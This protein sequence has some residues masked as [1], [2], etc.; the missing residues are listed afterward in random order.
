MIRAPL[1]NRMTPVDDVLDELGRDL[2]LT[3]LRFDPRG[4]V[5]LRFASGRCFSFETRDDALVLFVAEPVRHALGERVL[6]A[7]RRADASRVSPW[8]VQVV[9]RDDAGQP[10]LLAVARLE[11]GSVA[12]PEARRLLAFLD[13]WN[14]PR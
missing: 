13:E 7:M 5:S 4:H 1:M 10:A 9:V 14:P 8:P 3:T 12:F 11:A 2:G 6:D